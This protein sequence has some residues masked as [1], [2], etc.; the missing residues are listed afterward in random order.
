MPHLI[1]LAMQPPRFIRGGIRLEEFWIDWLTD[2][3]EAH[4]VSTP[5]DRQ[6]EVSTSLDRQ[7]EVS[8]SLD[9]RGRPDRR[10]AS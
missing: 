9:P 5:L 10:G 3:L 8:T 1:D 2:Y 7:D 6:D 4:R